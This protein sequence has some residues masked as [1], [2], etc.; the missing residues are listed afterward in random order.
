MVGIL[1]A[2]DNSSAPDGLVSGTM[3]SFDSSV[4]V[5]PFTAED[6]SMEG[7]SEVSVIP[8]TGTDGFTFTIVNWSYFNWFGS[9]CR[10]LDAV[11]HS[12]VERLMCPSIS[13]DS[14]YIINMDDGTLI[15]K[16]PLDPGNTGGWGSYPYVS[17]NVN[18][19]TNS[20]LFN[21]TNLGVNWTVYTNPSGSS[22]RGMDVDYS[23]DLVWETSSSSGVY[24]FT[25][26]ASSG[27]YYDLS[28]VIP[29][30]MSGLAVYENGG[31]HLLIVN[32]YN[33][34]SA[35]FFDLI[36]RYLPGHHG[37]GGEA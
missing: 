1:V 28:A 8:P 2:N 6:N 12:G 36:L 23:T 21:S 10:G 20:S 26:L 33:S 9:F 22:G 29:E 27:T 15:D 19:Y 3:N 16:L 35:Y 37:I 30:Q 14:L 31:N 34:T 17:A 25:H 24:S 32:T 5:V 7:Y 11:A 4:P 13:S 18:D